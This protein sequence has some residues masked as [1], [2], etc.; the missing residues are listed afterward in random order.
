MCKWTV[1]NLRA[2]ENDE[3]RG[4]QIR[5]HRMKFCEFVFPYFTSVICK[6]FV[7]FCRLI[8]EES[9]RELTYILGHYFKLQEKNFTFFIPVRDR[10]CPEINSRTCFV[11]YEDFFRLS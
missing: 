1:P 5:I 8:G 11:C 9:L 7:A 6:G 3:L 10:H 4:G 2:S